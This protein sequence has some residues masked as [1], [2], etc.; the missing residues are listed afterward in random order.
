VLF[1]GHFERVANPC[2]LTRRPERFEVRF[3]WLRRNGEFEAD[4]PGENLFDFVGSIKKG[5]APA[6]IT[7]EKVESARAPL[8]LPGI[9]SS[10]GRSARGWPAVTQQV[11]RAAFSWPRA[12][13]AAQIGGGLTTAPLALRTH[14]P[15]QLQ[16]AT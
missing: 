5:A 7:C 12:Q 2:L 4:S 16:K 1:L 6:K 11:H 10:E 9:P 8:R 15:F 14:P 3:I 13:T